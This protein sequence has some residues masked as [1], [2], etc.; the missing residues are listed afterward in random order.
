MQRLLILLAT[1]LLCVASPALAQEHHD[2]DGHD[3]GAAAAGKA[4]PSGPT[5]AQ[6]EGGQLVKVKVNGLVC[7]FCAQSLKKTLGRRAEIAGVDVN[8]STKLVSIRMKQGRNMS[9]AELEKLVRDA[10]YTPM[11]IDRS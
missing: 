1:G 5:A 2:H 11:N 4:A 6:T 10:G 7:D 9:N 8:L 3:H